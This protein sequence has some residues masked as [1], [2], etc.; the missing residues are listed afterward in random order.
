LQGK[1]KYIY[2]IVPTSI[3]D[4]QSGVTILSSRLFFIDTLLS[5]IRKFI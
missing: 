3:W 1:I 4:Q 2:K 5:Y